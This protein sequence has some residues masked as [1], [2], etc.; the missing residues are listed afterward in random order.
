MPGA[1]WRIVVVDDVKTDRTEGEEDDAALGAG[2]G[3]GA[4][5]EVSNLL[6]GLTVAAGDVRR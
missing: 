3:D 5:E 4:G 6:H 2:K 1:G